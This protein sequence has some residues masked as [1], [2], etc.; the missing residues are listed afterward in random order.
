M[1]DDL[2]EGIILR[3]SHTLY[4]YIYVPQ[5][6]LV[7]LP[8]CLVKSMVKSPLARQELRLL[9][10]GSLVDGGSKGRSSEGKSKETN[11]NGSGC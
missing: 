10:H 2:P 5:V 4:I 6:L 9:A 8:F 1:S 3:G 11:K 7:K